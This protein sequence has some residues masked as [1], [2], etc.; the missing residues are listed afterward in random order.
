MNQDYSSKFIFQ[1]AEK[2][3]IPADENIQIE[4]LD[5]TYDN[6][7][8]EYIDCAQK[9]DS[10]LK[11]YLLST[12]RLFRSFLP[13]GPNVFI[14]AFQIQWYYDE[15]IIFDPIIFQILVWQ[16]G[17]KEKDKQMLRMIFSFLSSFKDSISNNF[18]LFAGFN[19]FPNIPTKSFQHNYQRIA[20]SPEIREELD[21]LVYV[22]KMVK[23]SEEGEIVDFTIRTFYRG[24]QSFLPII[25]NP[26]IQSPNSNGKYVWTIDLI[27]SNYLPMTVEEVKEAG[28]YD[29]IYNNFINDYPVEIAEIINS[30]VAGASIK[31]PIL[32]NRRLDELVISKIS[33]QEEGIQR[34]LANNFY[35]LFLPFIDGIPPERLL[36]IRIN[37][38]NA[39]LDFRNT[40]FEIIFD[41]QSLNYEEEI[42]KLKIQQ[43]INPII[44]K[45][46]AEMKNSLNKARI[47]TI[48]VPIISG[49]GTFGLWQIGLDIT[50][51]SGLLLGGISI[52]AELK[53]I[54]DY[55]SE[56]NLLQTNPFY[57]LWKAKKEK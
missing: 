53:L 28:A 19:C 11:G 20:S 17:D 2:Y 26:Q 33:G 45:L 27:G 41:L 55:L 52:P 47:M 38:P 6:F 10:A 54:S 18:L 29:K 8:K 43:K 25:K 4:F 24:K 30:L 21:K 48:G 49:L 3:G 40:L 5:E 32:F 12:P 16:T 31:T 1:L 39:F 50:K 35:S 56:Q 13:W 51:I 37:M 7:C 22:A 46:D 36:D 34:S 9:R 14:T 15:L 44:K 23:K 42:L 57:Y